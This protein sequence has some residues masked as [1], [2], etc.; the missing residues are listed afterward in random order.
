[1]GKVLV[2][3]VIVAVVAVGA[4]FVAKNIAED[5]MAVEMREALELDDDPGVAVRGFPFLIHLLSGSLPEV[6]VDAEG[7]GDD[8]LRFD[9]GRLVLDNV[10]FEL[11]E[12]TSG[13]GD[14]R[15]GG[16]RGEVDAGAEA[17]TRAL[18]EAGAPI[19]VSIRD[20]RV[21]VT[22][23]TIPDEAE[24]DLDLEDGRLVLSSPSLRES[25]AVGLP[26]LGGRATYESLD[27]RGRTATLGV[28]LGAGTF[29][30]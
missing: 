29:R 2:V 27:T 19:D 8:G 17:I 10:R 24:G 23:N 3:V 22:A 20:G 1:M 15:F 28:R 6:A 13:S 16:G 18:R 9:R 25:Y 11:S 30:V 4:D 12:L 26:D 7:L 5:Q 14:V 21:F